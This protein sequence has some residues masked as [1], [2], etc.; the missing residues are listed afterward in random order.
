MLLPHEPWIYLPT[1]Q[2]FSLGGHLVGLRRDGVW[3]ADTAAVARNYQR[4]LLQV[5]HADMLL[6]VL[7]DRLRQV[8][9]FDDSLIVVTADHG[10]SFRPSRPFRVPTDATF[11]DITSV[12]LFI[13][14]PHQRDRAV[15][16][17]NVETVDIVPTLA[18]ELGTKLPWKADGFNAFEPMPGQRPTKEIF[19]SNGRGHLVGPGDL[20]DRI[21]EAV[22][23]KFA[24]FGT[25]DP[26]DQPKLGVRDELVGRSVSSLVVRRRSRFDVVV[27]TPTLWRDVD[28]DADFVPAHIT[29]AINDLPEGAAPPVLAVELNGTI[30]G[31]TRPYSFR[32]RGR[33]NAWEVIIDPQRCLWSER[34]ETGTWSC[35]VPTPSPHGRA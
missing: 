5:Q 1:G 4:H 14:R 27:D 33:K 25:G 19:Y 2:T 34:S 12:P 28:H 26:L 10:A 11:V 7:F 18:A 15:W 32:A 35:T 8:G 16:T 17:H 30:V 24:L 31:V 9:L 13:K 6:G 22:A 20:E 23:W 29:G 3:V 21:A